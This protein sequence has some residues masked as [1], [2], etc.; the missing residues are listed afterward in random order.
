MCFA[1]CV[2]GFDAYYI[3]N[4]TT[5][6]FS[7]T[8]CSSSASQRGVFYSQSNFSGIKIPLIKGQLA[9][10]VIMFTLCLAYIIIYIISIRAHRFKQPTSVYPQAPYSLSY[11]PAVSNG[12]L[13]APAT[14][15][16]PSMV[17][18]N[19]DGRGNKLVCPTCHTVMHIT[20]IKRPPM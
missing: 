16:R 12:L 6:Y 2:I 7:L 20:A 8:I 19:G 17:P 18:N 14:N 10:G 3:S 13:T 4:P 11:P 9:A 1:L 15:H 5:C